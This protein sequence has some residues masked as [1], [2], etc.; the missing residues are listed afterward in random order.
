MEQQKFGMSPFLL[1]AIQESLRRLPCTPYDFMKVKKLTDFYPVSFWA[2]VIPEMIEEAKG[3][4][5]CIGEMPNLHTLVFS[6]FKRDIFFVNDFSFLNKC[7]KLRKLDLQNTNF[8]DCEVLLHMPKLQQVF[9]PEKKEMFHTEAI[10]E[11]VKRGVKVFIA[12]EEE[13]NLVSIGHMQQIIAEIQKQTQKNCMKLEIMPD[14]V[15]GL[16]DSKFG[17]IPYWNPK[18][19]Y[20]KGE[21]GQKLLLLAQLNF[22]GQEAL[23]PLPQKGLLQF[24]IAD[25]AILGLDFDEPDVQKNFRVVYH[26]EPDTTITIEDVKALGIPDLEEADFFPV[27]QSVAVK[28]VQDIC[29]MGPKVTGFEPIFREIFQQ[30]T[31]EDISLTK[32]NDWFESNEIDYINDEIIS[33]RMLGYPDFSWIGSDPRDENSPYDTLLFQIDSEIYDGGEEYILWGDGSVANFFIRHEDLENLD[34]SRVLYYW[35]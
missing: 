14:V 27:L 18:E 8:S 16:L 11:L 30:I 15:P 10:E 32:W 24:F 31:G 29:Y 33:H 21:D 7:K 23:K 4:F 28:M 34:F 1:G 2:D 13:R 19:P 5:S 25:D 9:L 12:G 17:G 6:N 22:D 20:P 26:P 3:D 35:F